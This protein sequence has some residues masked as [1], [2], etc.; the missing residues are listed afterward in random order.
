MPFTLL[1]LYTPRTPKHEQLYS[2]IALKME[3]KVCENNFKSHLG[4]YSK[5]MCVE[6]SVQYVQAYNS[7]VGI[8]MIYVVK[9]IYYGNIF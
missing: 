6:G 5:Y 4:I 3:Y 2:V 8:K 7:R 9:T 1:A